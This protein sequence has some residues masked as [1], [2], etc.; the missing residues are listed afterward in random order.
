MIEWSR[1]CSSIMTNNPFHRPIDAKDELMVVL[2][3]KANKFLI[4]GNVGPIEV[5]I[6]MPKLSDS[7]SPARGLAIV[8]HPHPLMGGTMDNKVAQTLAKTLSGLGYVAVRFNFRGV[9]Q[10]AGVHDEG[11]GEVDDTLKV[12]DWARQ[13]YATND[14]LVLAGFSFGTLVQSRVALRLQAQGEKIERMVF[15]GTAAGKWAVEP[16]PQ[17]TIVIH[18]ELDDVIT[19][20]DVFRWAEPQE[21]PV[22]V[23]AGADHFF[24]RRLHVI[25]GIIERQWTV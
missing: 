16:V 13:T 15:V 25:R 17:D 14:A 10:S 23:V 12:I 21:L 8:A 6:D 2:N 7:A 9:G 19:L 18:G 3:P 11:N 4:D 1:D 24:H 5:Q 22:T 20:H